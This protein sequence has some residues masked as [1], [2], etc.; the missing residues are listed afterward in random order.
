MRKTYTRWVGATDVTEEDGYPGVNEHH[1]SSLVVV[2]TS[3]SDD[4]R[5][6]IIGSGTLSRHKVDMDYVFDLSAHDK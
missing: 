4:L 6:E 2:Y 5:R 3:C 1:C